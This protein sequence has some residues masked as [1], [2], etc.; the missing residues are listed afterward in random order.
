MMEDRLTNRH[1][2]LENFKKHNLQKENTLQKMRSTI[3]HYIPS[4]R[5]NQLR[6]IPME[7]LQQMP[8]EMIFGDLKHR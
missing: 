5:L 7:N 6:N 2:Y 8:Y 3:L 1:R 4:E